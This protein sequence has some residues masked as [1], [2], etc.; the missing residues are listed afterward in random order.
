MR[1][2]TELAQVAPAASAGHGRYSANYR[3]LCA[4]IR[5]GRPP[6]ALCG[7][8]INYDAPP[9]HPDSFTVDHKLP[10]STHPWLAE[11]PGNLQASHWRCNSSKGAGQAKPGLG[12][13][14]EAW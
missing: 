6:C 14:S 7:Q 1:R 13:T 10:R 2:S 4:N 3:R 12:S 8:Q 9:R 5:A 11:D